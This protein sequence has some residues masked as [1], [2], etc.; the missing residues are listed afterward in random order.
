MKTWVI[1]HKPRNYPLYFYAGIF[2]LVF[3]SFF[4]CVVLILLN[5]QSKT[6]LFIGFLVII[7]IIVGLAYQLG[8]KVQEASLIF[9]EDTSHRLYVID[10][11]QTTKSVT[12]QAKNIEKCLRM[13]EENQKLP[14]SARQIAFIDHIRHR[15]KR[16]ILYC[17]DE[18]GQP[19]MLIVSNRCPDIESLWLCLERIP[20]TTEP[21]S[22]K[23]IPIFIGFLCLFLF[24]I[25]ICTQSHPYIGNLPSVI[26]FPMLLISFILLIIVS[27]LIVKIVR[28]E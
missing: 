23:K 3:L 10:I 25:F 26:Y 4:L 18:H 11:R 14:Q 21:K 12:R 16:R 24:S 20:T 15:F 13:I 2:S 1:L 9:I 17:Q 19:F 5:I 22:D 27:Y 7:S 28:H 8:F 6:I